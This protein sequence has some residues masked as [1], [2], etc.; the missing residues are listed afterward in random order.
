MQAKDDQECKTGRT[1]KWQSHCLDLYLVYAYT[2]TVPF[3]THEKHPNKF[4]CATIVSPGSAADYEK[5]PF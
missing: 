2:Y 4:G 5:G 1:V 3:S